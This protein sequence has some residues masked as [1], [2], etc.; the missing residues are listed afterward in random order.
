MPEQ[1]MFAALA[2]IMLLLVEVMWLLQ[3][4]VWLKLV[5][6]MA[7]SMLELELD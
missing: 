6:L 5:I 2:V 1:R 7:L 3:V 4:F